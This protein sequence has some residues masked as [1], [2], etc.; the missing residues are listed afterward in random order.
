MVGPDDQG[1]DLDDVL[2]FHLTRDG[3]ILILPGWLPESEW[4]SEARLHEEIRH[5]H[6]MKGKLLY[7][8][9][10]PQS[11]PPEA[12]FELFRQVSSAGLPIQ[13]VEEPHPDTKH[14]PWERP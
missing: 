6:Q 14:R 1:E 4:V 13:F 8:R 5:C 3:H 12:V 11:A 10:D 9:D 2:Y 7:S